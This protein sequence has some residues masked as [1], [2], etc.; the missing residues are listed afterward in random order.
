[1]ESSVCQVL[2]GC[3]G[4]VIVGLIAI[5]TESLAIV[6]YLDK[7]AT[8]AFRKVIREHLGGR[9]RMPD[10]MLSWHRLSRCQHAFACAPGMDFC[11]EHARF[12]DGIVS[13]QLGSLFCSHPVNG[14]S[15]QFARV[16]ER[17]R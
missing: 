4:K 14:D 1:M 9:W 13:R 11:F 17:E 5:D 2:I 3:F 12:D 7:P 15:H 8:G 10:G 6:R 16:V